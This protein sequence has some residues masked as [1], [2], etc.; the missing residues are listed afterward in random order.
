MTTD[1]D[2]AEHRS[3]GLLLWP[4]LVLTLALTGL[5]I[6]IP[7]TGRAAVALG[8][9][10]HAP[11]FGGLALG[12]LYLLEQVRPLPK[13]LFASLRRGVMVFL[14]MFTFGVGTEF[15]QR[16]LGRDAALRDAVA[17]GLGIVAAV[18][19]YWSLQVRRDFR[20]QRLIP[21]MLWLTC[22]ILLSLAWWSPLRTLSDVAAMR[23]NFPLLAS[24]ESK[25]ELRR[26]Y[27]RQCDAVLT[28]RDATLGT[29]SME[30][31]Y[32]AAPFPAATL[33]ELVSDWSAMQTLEL[34]VTLDETYSG[35]ALQFMVKVLDQ[36]HRRGDHTDTYR[37][38]WE[39]H[40][41]ETRHLCIT[42]DQLLEGPDDRSLDLTKIQFVDLIVID[43][44]ETAKLRIDA[45]RL[46]F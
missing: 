23:L 40:P 11:L 34:D 46:E 28:K 33:G 44:G 35:D 30:V 18:L 12:I 36:H 15:L 41:G 29:Y 2:Q 16:V 43:P 38:Q 7:Y 17:N 27:F 1:V 32:Q 26:F 19:W 25:T 6:P 22:G 10:A 45:L 37:G 20:D 39:L 8:D 42:R 24:F 14:A 21:R 31:T 13:T 3:R 4:L 9:L 5:L